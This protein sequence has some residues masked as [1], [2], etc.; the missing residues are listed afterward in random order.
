MSRRR[1]VG[2][3]VAVVLLLVAV[4]WHRSRSTTTTQNPTAQQHKG[5]GRSIGTLATTGGPAAQKRIAGTV[6]LESAPAAGAT[7]RLVDGRSGTERVVQ[8]DATGHFD[9]GGVLLG[10]YSVLAE[11]S[12]ATG[13][14]TFVD[15]RNPTPAPPADQLRLVAHAC[16]AVL[17]GVVRDAS[18]GTIAKARIA[19]TS[20]FITGPGVES[21]DDGS[22]ELCVSIGNN[23]IAVRADGYA[24]AVAQV[25]AYGK[26]HRDF[27]LVPEAVVAGRAVRADDGSAVAGARVMLVAERPRFNGVPF[28]TAI[29]DSDGQFRFHGVGRGSYMLSATASHLITAEPQAINADLSAPVEDAKCVLTAALS[30]AGRV[31]DSHKKPV[32]GATVSMQTMRSF[33]WTSFD[34]GV[35]TQSDGS[36]VF[37]HLTPGDYRVRVRDY[38]LA[39]TARQ[40]TL[41]KS[42]LTDVVLEVEALGSIAGRVTRAGKPVEGASVNAKPVDQKPR[43]FDNYTSYAKSDADGRFTLRG[44]QAG[45]YNV[46]AQ[47]ERVGAFTQGPRV[48]LG[49]AENMTG[50]EVEMELAGSIAGVV[51]DQ[52]DA[53]VAGVHLSFSLLHGEDGGQATTGDD[54]TFKASALSGGGD[55]IYEIRSA[56]AAQIELHPVDGKRFP[57]IAVK[58]G[59]T[60]VTGVRIKV[61]YDRLSITGRVLTSTGEGAADVSVTAEQD[62]QRGWAAPMATTDT[63]GRFTLR[64]LPE[65]TY[66]I[67]AQAANAS[68]RVKGVAAGTK[69]VELKLPGLG[70]IDGTLVGFTKAPTLMAFMTNDDDMMNAVPLRAT[71]TVKKFSFANVPVGQYSIMARSDDGYATGEATVRIGAKAEVTLTN[72]GVGTVEGRVVDEKGAPVADIRCMGGGG[73]AT[74]SDS[75]GRFK[76]EHVSAG[77]T[78]VVCFNTTGRA[79]GSTTVEAGGTAHIDIVLKA[80]AAAFTR[81]Y[82]GLQFETRL[83]D[84]VVKQVES[85]SPGEAAG[86]KVGD[87]LEK[88]GER[89][90]DGRWGAENVQRMIESR[91]AGTSVKLTIERDDKE[92]TVE[93]KLEA[94]R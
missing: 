68:Q 79:Q 92:Q 55:Y 67:R 44:L 78:S 36:F 21:E 39:K 63:S 76:L 11:V 34:D 62:P 83:S 45:T 70:T 4:F 49:D 40:L 56:T 22:Y 5:S 24:D 66:T 12:H 26:L 32:V 74:Q 31:V 86:V 51:V 81:S 84:V 52:N 57:P 60:Q 14:I 75:D 16:E 25:A 38:S 6:F 48:T 27:D 10:K 9:F 23:T 7:V 61:R 58:D 71:G 18:G 77:Q 41:D 93:V 53:P 90:V 72:K 82:A 13:A 91:P 42:D 30:V 47:S 37:D 89:A 54:G 65:G 15:L 3:V 35:V 20:G 33:D 2:V 17:Q 85:K 88:I 19:E 8:A 46:Y 94:P 43:D 29:A 69:G 87:V 80:G 1:T 28:F 73:R 64:D 59:N 50:V